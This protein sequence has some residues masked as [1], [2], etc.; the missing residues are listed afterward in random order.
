MKRSDSS[1]NFLVLRTIK[2]WM[3]PAGK[4]TRV[5][6]FGLY[7]GIQFDID[8]RTQAQLYFG[9]WEAETHRDLKKISK[10]VRTAIDI[11]AAWGEQTLYFLSK[12]TA[13]KIY[14]FEPATECCESIRKNT[15]LNKLEGSRLEI[16]QKY[17]GPKNDARTVTLDSLLDRIEFP[18]VV[19]MDIDGGE[20]D[21]L[22]GA[23]KL[24]E[25]S[26]VR[27]LVETHTFRLERECIELFKRHGHRTKIIDNAW[28][29]VVLPEQR[30]GEMNRWLLALKQ[31]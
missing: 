8:L 18:C 20:V 23:E 19:K 5:I 2:N 26:G 31:P 21:A 4:R 25:A 10:G 1:S 6:P 27:W 14:A 30:P 24:M 28:W 13:K 9:L 7:R 15:A 11:G 16:I 22:K 17:V 3:L 12:T 29:R